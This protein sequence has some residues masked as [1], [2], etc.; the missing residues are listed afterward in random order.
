MTSSI[1]IKKT[2]DVLSVQYYS[3]LLTFYT[4]FILFLHN[5][6]QIL[7]REKFPTFNKHS[8][9]KFFFILLLQRFSLKQPFRLFFASYAAN[10]HF[11]L[12]K[13]LSHVRWIT[14]KTVAAHSFT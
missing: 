3:T 8:K 11:I 2:R 6:A 4:V 1:K 14:A 10:I 12:R 7:Q 13:H 5:V 9:R